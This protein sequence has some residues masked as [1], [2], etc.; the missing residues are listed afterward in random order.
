MY[1]IGTQEEAITQY[2]EESYIY[3]QG[4]VGTRFLAYDILSEE[5][6]GNKTQV[7]IWMLSRDYELE[8]D[9]KITFEQSMSIPLALT[10]MPVDERNWKVTDCLKPGEKENYADSVRN[11]LP[12]G[13][14][15]KLLSKKY[16]E[17]KLG[18]QI[19]KK[20]R[21]YYNKVGINFDKI[22]KN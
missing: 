13:I 12:A 19:Q 22:F 15:E 10:L 1:P 5:N 2:L 21:D 7:Y 4:L 9:R 17:Q 6:S 16:D 3:S 18:E 8:E 14:S 20:A 11:I